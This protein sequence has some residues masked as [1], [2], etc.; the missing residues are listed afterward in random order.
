M[1]S[2]DPRPGRGSTVVGVESE[3]RGIGQTARDCGLTVSALRFYDAAG[4][5]APAW[6]DPVSG[7][8]WY[9]RAQVRD[10]RLIARLRRI[11]LPLPDIAR[12]VSDQHDRRLVEHLLAAH[13]RRLEDGL[14]DARRELSAVRA[15][16]DDQENAMTVSPTTTVSV[17]ADDL[18][19]ALRAVRFAAGE[20][21]ALPTLRGLLLDVEGPL[22]R[23]V[24]TDRYRLA[25][26]AAP[27]TVAGPDVSVLAPLDLVDELGE[28]LLAAQGPVTLLLGGTDIA[29]QTSNGS[30]AGR[31]LDHDFPDYRRL[32]RSEETPGLPVEADAL[33]D[34]IAAAPHLV[35]RREQDDVEYDVTTLAVDADGRLVLDGQSPSL[36][37]VGVN[38]E[39]LLEALTAPGAA[40]LT[41][42]LDG[43][44]GPLAIR[45]PLRPQA[46]SL[47]MPVRLP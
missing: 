15:H 40:Q 6:V 22:L 24:A 26:A 30:V 11:G 39:F 9:G 3:L 23:L 25:V 16:L 37:Q 18:L 19:N 7:Y 1:R 38:R 34:Q 14:A 46:V 41:L 43:P 44:I 36:V 5:L 32:L 29:V 45:D 33:R 8:R 17:D 13:L 47:L 20:D 31:R 42:S 10:A 4:V 35:L 21:P 27:A 28:L 12:V 2:L